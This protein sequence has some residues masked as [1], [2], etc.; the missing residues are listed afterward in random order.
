MSKYGGAAVMCVRCNKAVYFQEQMVAPGGTWHKN[1]LTCTECNKRLDSTNISENNK[2]VYCKTCHGR[3]FGPKGYGFG[4]GAG[5][6]SMDTK[7]S[8]VTATSQSRITGKSEANMSAS[9]DIPNTDS[10][11]TA[12]VASS[13]TAGDEKVYSANTSSLR[14]AYEGATTGSSAVN[15]APRPAS[16]AASK[17]GGAEKCTRCTKAVYFAEQVIGPGNLKYHKTCFKCSSCNKQ[18]DTG[19]VSSKDVAI[20]CKPC[21]GRQFGPKGYGFGG[22]AGVLSTEGF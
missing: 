11:Q 18:L 2:Q 12:Y 17:Y 19:S 22:G 13:A 10:S 21:H 15:H 9:T 5:V 1:C 3:M 4:G 16:A 7:P 20:F 8:M 14:S 6:L